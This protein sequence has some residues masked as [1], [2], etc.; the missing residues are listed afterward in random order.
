MGEFTGVLHVH[1]TFSDG[2]MSLPEIR[3]WAAGENLDF[4]CVTDHSDALR[5]G[6]IEA[7]I[8]ACEQ[9]SNEVL[10]VPG[11]EFSGLGRHVI[12][13]ATPDVLMDLTDD[14]VVH[15]PELVRERG[16]LT[17]W[18]HPAQTYAVSMRNAINAAYDGW[19][20]WNVKVDGDHPNLVLAGLLERME[21]ERSILPFRGL[22]LHRLPSSEIPM[23]RTTI[24]VDELSIETVV[25]SFRRGSYLMPDERE[26]G[27]R[28]EADGHL[29]RKISSL[30]ARIRHSIVRA[31]CSTAIT[32][33]HALKP[34]K[35]TR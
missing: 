24:H 22:D 27:A 7:Y 28:H 4:V 34:L 16:G 21:R 26:W 5:D 19:E 29:S 12:A 13:L 23:P 31:R 3:D 35:L 25:D 15:C 32:L 30:S 18:A 6:G 33:H 1:S 14:T 9:I 8:S 17:I 20:I 11:V 2:A 10:L